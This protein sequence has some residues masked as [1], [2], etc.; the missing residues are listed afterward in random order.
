MSKQEFLN[1]CI[2]EE[3]QYT[4]PSFTKNDIWELGCCLVNAC[5]EKDGPLAVT[6]SLGSLEVF[7]YYPDGTSP[8]HEMWLNRKKR[9]VY[10]ME[11]ST[12]RL[13]AELEL[14]G[15][16]LSQ[17]GLNEVEFVACGGGFPLRIRGGCVIG[18]IGV[19]GMD[20]EADQSALLDGLH[21]FFEKRGLVEP[22]T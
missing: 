2:A 13:K 1:Q 19:S 20:D 5:R 12:M 22:K 10:V 21:R 15:S 14:S 16:N 8:Y 18:F 6:I 4:F 9:T 17:E 3:Q 7:R 11:R